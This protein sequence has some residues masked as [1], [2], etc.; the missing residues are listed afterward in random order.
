MAYVLYS[1]CLAYVLFLCYVF[2]E[3]TQPCDVLKG[4]KRKTE[5]CDESVVKMLTGEENDVEIVENKS[6]SR[7]ESLQ[8]SLM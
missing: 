5:S 4:K 6:K 1:V 3:L 7:H 2:S 8:K